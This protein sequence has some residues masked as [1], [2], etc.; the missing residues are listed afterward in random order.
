MKY[1]ST[2][3]AQGSKIIIVI[4]LVGVVKTYVAIV[5]MLKEKGNTYVT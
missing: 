3:N 4:V 2:F 1:K 5:V